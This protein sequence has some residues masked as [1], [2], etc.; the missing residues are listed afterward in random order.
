VGVFGGTFDPP[1]VGHVTVARDVADA[2]GLDRVLWIP[3]RTPPH[4]TDREISPGPVRREMTAAAAAADPRFE[5]S[6][7]ELER[8]GPSWTVDTLRLLRA[9]DPRAA[10][11][12]ILGADQVRTLDTGWR[13]PEEVL[14]LATLAVMDRAGA[15]AVEVAPDV[16]GIERAVHVPVTRVDVSSSGIRARVRA[17]EDVAELLP[18]GVLEIILREALYVG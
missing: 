9:R 13:E 15:S 4:K 14:S 16:P 5:V 18:P 12:L 6:D 7:V 10:L 11:F 3:A 1:H 17:G 8:E 2:L